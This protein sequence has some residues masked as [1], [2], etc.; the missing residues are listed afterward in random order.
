M[1]GGAGGGGSSRRH[2]LGSIAAAQRDDDFRRKKSAHT[3]CTYDIYEYICRMLRYTSV[4]GGA[5]QQSFEISLCW[6]R[7]GVV[8]TPQ[9]S[10]AASPVNALLLLGR[11]DTYIIHHTQNDLDVSGQQ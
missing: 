7:T 1:V 3:T 8:S 11:S 4:G 9:N 5:L 10:I 2:I 6:W